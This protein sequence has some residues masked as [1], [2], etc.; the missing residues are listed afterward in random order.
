MTLAEILRSQ[1]LTDDQIATIEGEM[2]QNKIF[3]S[4]EEN[5]D[6]RFGKLQ[7]DFNAKTKEHADA[8]ATI[9]Q[10]RSA[11]AGNADTAQQISDAQ[12]R[13]ATLEA[14]NAEIRAE[15]AA[16]MA[17]LSH[18]AKPEDI[19][20]LLFTYKKEH[21]GKFELD[22]KGELKGFDI[23]ALKTAKPNNFEAA[24]VRK[25][26]PHKLQEGENEGNGITKAQFDAMSYKERAELYETD[27]ETYDKLSKN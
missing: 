10:L 27:R 26:D 8:L 16:K 22:E 14:E 17:L 25:V 9:E 18:K 15:N 12:A 3:T 19:D 2:K 6:I 7:T 23:E 11:A 24:S 1:G 5:I 13:I 21:G 20:Y 4:A